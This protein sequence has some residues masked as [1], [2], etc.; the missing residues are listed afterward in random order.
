MLSEE[1]RAKIHE[2]ALKI[3]E[4]NNKLNSVITYIDEFGQECSEE[5]AKKVIIREYNQVG[6]L[7]K[8]TSGIIGDENEPEAISEGKK[9]N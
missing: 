2:E 5:Y 7:V 8:E 3:E 1:E 6:E 4:E 9:L